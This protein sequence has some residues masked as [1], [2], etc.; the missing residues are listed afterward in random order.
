MRLVLASGSPRRRELLTALGFDFDVVPSTVDEESFTGGRPVAL[1]RRIARAKA[2]DVASREPN[3]IVLAADTIV[4]LRGDVLNKPRDAEEARAMLTRLRDRSHRVVTG[5]CVVQGRRVRM[6]HVVT[7]VRMRPYAA[8]EIEASIARGDPLDK[9]GAYAIQD[10]RFAP[11]ASYEGCYCNVVGLP[12]WTSL[13]LLR[14]AGVTR[15]RV[16][17]MPAACDACLM[18]P[19][20]LYSPN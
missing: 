19:K 13:R 12:L 18:K 2:E 10:D 11:V 16:A 3:A 6:A 8:H 14:D 17:I 15:T 5:V 1:A 9:A 7:P 20:D 4:V